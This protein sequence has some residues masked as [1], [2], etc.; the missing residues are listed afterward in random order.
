LSVF[1]ELSA[2]LGEIDNIE[3]MAPI[4]LT[5]LNKAFPRKGSS[6]HCGLLLGDDLVLKAYHP[7][8]KPPTCSTSLAR[9]VLTKKK[10]L[11]LECWCSD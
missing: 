6:M 8:D 3:L 11:P 1:F 9:Y 2:A 4:L 10:S 7:D 5:H